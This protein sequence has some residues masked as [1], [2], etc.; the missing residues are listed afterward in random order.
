[1]SNWSYSGGNCGGTYTTPNGLI[2]SPDYPDDYPENSDCTY[3]ILQP[4]GTKVTM[5][6][7]QLAVETDYEDS[8]GSCKTKD[9]LEIRDG[10]DKDAPL[11]ATVCGKG[12]DSQPAIHSTQNQVW[13]R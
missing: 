5:K 8:S 4:Q 1:M 2:A 10:A 13:M 7:L 9:Y 3:K 12:A 6:I 11:L